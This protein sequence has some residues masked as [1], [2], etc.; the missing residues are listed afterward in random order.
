[1]LGLVAVDPE[2]KKVSQEWFE[3]VLEEPVRSSVP[4]LLQSLTRTWC[5]I[6]SDIKMPALP[7]VLPEAIWGVGDWRRVG[8]GFRAAAA[9]VSRY[10]IIGNALSVEEATKLTVLL[11][12]PP[13]GLLDFR[14]CLDALEFVDSE[15]LLE[16]LEILSSAGSRP[17]LAIP[18]P[19]KIGSLL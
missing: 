19:G 17:P 3:Q 1:M 5:W 15:A 14:G 8:L 4:L 9:Q 18:Y 13:S 12:H 2:H 16:L 11:S 6:D 7:E 10:V